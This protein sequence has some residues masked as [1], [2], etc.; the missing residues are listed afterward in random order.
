MRHISIDTFGT[1]AARDGA[2]FYPKRRRAPWYL[3]RARLL[4]TLL[5]F[6]VF[7]TWL[8]FGG[9]EI[10]IPRDSWDYVRDGSVTD[11]MNATL[12]VGRYLFVIRS[13][14]TSHMSQIHC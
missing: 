14:P 6:L 1:K 5:C 4:T 10:V 8:N 11:I 13:A 2:A 12:G 9:R 7:Y 3:S